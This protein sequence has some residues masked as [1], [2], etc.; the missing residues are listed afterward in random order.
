MCGITS[1]PWEKHCPQAERYKTSSQT[2]FFLQPRSNGVPVCVFSSMMEHHVTTVRDHQISIQDDG[3]ETPAIINHEATVSVVVQPVW[4]S[5]LCP[6]SSQVEVWAGWT[7]LLVELQQ[8]YPSLFFSSL[9]SI[10]ASSHSVVITML[11]PNLNFKYVLNKALKLL[12]TLP[13]RSL[14]DYDHLVQKLKCPRELQKDE[15]CK[16]RLFAWI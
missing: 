7:R 16:H 4:V 10:Y 11:S 2:N 1:H 12:Q 8:P 5:P 9:S 6:P 14:H 15:H 3:W 13:V